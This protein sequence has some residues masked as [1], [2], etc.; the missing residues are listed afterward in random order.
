MI[1]RA[2]LRLPLD[3]CALTG[4][5][6]VPPPAPTQQL[7]S[8]PLTRARLARFTSWAEYAASWLLMLQ[9]PPML[10]IGSSAATEAAA[11]KAAE[12][13]THHACETILYFWHFL[14]AF[15]FPVAFSTLRYARQRPRSPEARAAAASGRGRFAT[16]A[17][18]FDDAAADALESLWAAPATGVLLLWSCVAVMFEAASAL[19]GAG[20][21]G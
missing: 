12:A 10:R 3:C 19:A 18:A 14:L 2:G 4:P 17:A 13:A 8:A 9:I 16:A 6:F 7:L 1:G 5:N 15:A 21:G 11:S 20:R